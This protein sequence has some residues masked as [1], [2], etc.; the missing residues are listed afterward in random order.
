MSLGGCYVSSNGKET[1]RLIGRDEIFVL[2]GLLID[3]MLV[4]NAWKLAKIQEA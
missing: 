2:Y 4:L 1:F 3:E